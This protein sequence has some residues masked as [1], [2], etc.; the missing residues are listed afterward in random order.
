M[1]ETTTMIK[2]TTATKTMRT[3][4]T[5]MTTTKE[6]TTMMA[7]TTAMTMKM[8]TAQQRGWAASLAV[9]V[10]AAAIVVVLVAAALA[11]SEWWRWWGWRWRKAAAALTVALEGRRS[12]AWQR[13]VADH[14]GDTTAMLRSCVVRDCASAVHIL[15]SGENLGPF[16]QYQI[17]GTI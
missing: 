13:L 8:K 16:C 11:D 3:I 9:A 5:L 4:K 17:W 10:L 6:K 12:V 14:Q 7:K 15:L 2:M 1:T